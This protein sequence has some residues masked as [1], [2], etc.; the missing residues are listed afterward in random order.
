MFAVLL[1]V[2]PLTA[3]ITGV[4]P[5]RLLP[6]TGGY[7]PSEVAAGSSLRVVGLGDSVMAGSACGCPGIPADYADRLGAAT[8]RPVSGV[9]LGVPGATTTD[10]MSRIQTDRQIVA[11]LAGA[12]VVIVTVG[13]NDLLPQQQRWQVDG[14]PPQCYLPA[15]RTM[16][17]RLATVLAEIRALRVGSPAAILVT[18]YWNVYTDG[19]GA[20]SSGGQRQLDWSEQVTEAANRVIC[21]A[22]TRQQATCVD[23]DRWFDDEGSDPT[24]LLAADGDHPNAAG[25][26]V[27]VTALLAATR[28]GA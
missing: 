8:R 28:V 26:D 9:N 13:A 15:A 4:G 24:R 2:I 5:V 11:A 3:L 1:I 16:G 12:D 6:Q 23:L 21:S 20:L 27:I 22:A 19:A 10:L 14:C 18:T 17:D 7:R 25:V